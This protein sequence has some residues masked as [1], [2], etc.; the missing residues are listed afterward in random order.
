MAT[1]TMH[2]LAKESLGKSAEESLGR[3]IAEQILR[4]SVSAR[5]QGAGLATEPGIPAHVQMRFHLPVTKR[6]L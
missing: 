4:F 3:G 1:P 5:F 6:T 2:P